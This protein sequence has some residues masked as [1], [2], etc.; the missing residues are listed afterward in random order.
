MKRTWFRLAS[1]PLAPVLVA[2]IFAVGVGG[3]VG[4]CLAAEASAVPDPLRVGI[5]PEYPPLVFRQPEG[6]NGLEIDFAKALGQ[7]LGRPVEFVVLRWDEEIPALLDRRIDII[8]SGLS[9]TP[10]RRLRIAFSTPYLQNQLRAIFPRKNAAR[11]QTVEQVT[12]SKERIGV[13]AGTTGELFVKRSCP[14]AEIVPLTMRRDIGFYLIKGNRMDLFIDDTFALADILSRNEADLAYLQ[15]PLSQE[16][17]AWGI[18][19]GDADLLDQVN[20]VL[21]RWKS[22][23]TLERTINRWIPYLKNIR[24]APPAT[25]ASGGS[26]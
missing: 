18:R 5:T 22:N 4:S 11:Y 10:A 21:E 1:E 9:I 2:V 20:K 12:Q 7:Q 16:E 25:Q 24:S 17:L 8:M 6:T 13:I 14:E 23:G 19:P 26:P 15:T 3:M